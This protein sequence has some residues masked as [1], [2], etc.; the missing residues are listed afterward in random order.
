LADVLFIRV[1]TVP[2]NSE[3]T[4]KKYLTLET[5]FMSLNSKNTPQNL[6]PGI[7]NVRFEIKPNWVFSPSGSVHQSI[8]AAL[9]Q[10]LNG[11]S[12]VDSNLQ[13]RGPHQRAAI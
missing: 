8:C 9:Q 12:Q 11:S 3:K 10:N 2:E 1:H 7:T 4:W 5:V 13:P 6:N